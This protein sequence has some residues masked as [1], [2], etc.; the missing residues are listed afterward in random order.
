VTRMESWNPLKTIHTI[1]AIASDFH[2]LGGVYHGLAELVA[3][4]R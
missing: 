3:E 2:N 4:E 1:C